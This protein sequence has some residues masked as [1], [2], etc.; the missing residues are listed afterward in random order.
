[1]SIFDNA[2]CT[3]RGATAAGTF[4]SGGPYSAARAMYDQ[5]A[6]TRRTSSGAAVLWGELTCGGSVVGRFGVPGGVIA[7]TDPAPDTGLPSA[8]DP[9]APPVPPPTFLDR[10]KG[11]LAAAA[12]AVGLILWSR[13]R[14]NPRRRRR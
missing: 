6:S 13:P 2:T 5:L 8:F 4:I 10:Y 14:K 12:V 9:A 3:V 1:M 7:P 11:P